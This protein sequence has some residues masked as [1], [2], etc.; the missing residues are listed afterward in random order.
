[1]RATQLLRVWLGLGML[2]AASGQAGANVLT[3]GSFDGGLTGWQTS[4]FGEQ[5]QLSLFWA[6]PSDRTGTPGSS[7]GIMQNTS[8]AAGT[9][10]TIPLNDTACFAVTDAD[11]VNTSG[12]VLLPLSQNRT[13]S[14]SLSVAWFSNADCT[15]F[16][17]FGTPEDLVTA[18]D[19]QWH[20]FADERFPASGTNSMKVGLTL[21][22]T[23]AGGSLS[24]WFDDLVVTVPEAPGEAGGCAALAMLAGLAMPRRVR[25]RSGV[26]ALACVVAIGVAA[27]GGESEP[28]KPA[29]P[30]PAPAPAAAP[31]P[32]PAPAAAPAPTASPDAAKGAALYATNCASCHGAAGAGDG[33]AAVALVPKPARHDDGAYMNALTNEHLFRVVKEG[34][35]A[36]GKSPLMAPWGGMLSDAQIWDVVAFV[37]TLAKPPYVGSVP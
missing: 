14:A 5:I 33:P 24:A 3:N 36:V 30:A 25:R 12:W 31:A 32:A 10:G 1:M 7:A 27:C 35:P 23:E 6:E 28:A 19:G 4:S 15:G 22:K 37:R 11:V 2:F 20:T 34:G 16:A 29:A 21:R 17:G 8:P 26:I 9:F 13:G 18:I